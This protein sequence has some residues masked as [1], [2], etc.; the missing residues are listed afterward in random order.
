MH[1]TKHQEGRIRL[2]KKPTI[3]KLKEGWK[4]RVMGLPLEEWASELSR[5]ESDTY[6][7]T[8]H[9]G[10]LFKLLFLWSY[11]I[12]PYL[13]II[14]SRRAKHRSGKAIMFYADPY[15]GSGLCELPVKGG[16]AVPILGSGPLALLAPFKMHENHPKVKYSYLWDCVLLNEVDENSR[17]AL[18]KRLGYM[19]KNYENRHLSSPYHITKDL[20][21]QS[22][23]CGSRPI[24]ITGYD[25]T[26]A[27]YWHA[28]R[29]FLL[30]PLNQKTDWIH[31]L[32]FVDLPSPSQISL[33]GF[34]RLLE[35]PSDV[36]ILLH[37]GLFAEIIK[38]GLYRTMEKG[39]RYAL[40]ENA[41]E[42]I[43][44]DDLKRMKLEEISS[45][46][47]GIY[48]GVLKRTKIWGIRDGSQTRNK[49]LKFPIR[50]KRRHYTLLLGVR[51][52]QGKL[53][54]RWFG[55]ARDLSEEMSR[56]SELGEQIVD[57]SIARKQAVL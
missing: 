6:F 47:V 26:G 4:V 38:R 21:E 18:E 27:W 12:H 55:W 24:V 2:K 10:T 49:I 35:V 11:L 3:E 22:I 23:M 9:T 25:C 5:I 50:T 14:A 15:A 53:F 13:G 34:V 40:T 36:I 20:P 52:T 42:E 51:E 54:Q 7:S 43:S 39:L 1:Q 44:F 17:R 48:E 46:Y 57:I 33:A 30:K 37:D 31:G 19:L 16:G 56:L 8:K 32:L 29:E 45:Y 28:I 41:S